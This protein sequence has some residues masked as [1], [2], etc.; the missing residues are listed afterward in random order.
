MTH[1]KGKPLEFADNLGRPLDI[2]MAWYELTCIWGAHR[3][4]LHLE[5]GDT[6]TLA[7]GDPEAR[8][9]KRNSLPSYVTIP[10]S[11]VNPELLCGA[12]AP[13][14]SGGPGTL[15]KHFS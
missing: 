13:S 1:D 10:T 3:A 8:T 6:L 11:Q 9:C 2:C 7:F 4:P 5:L 15:G 12:W 14:L